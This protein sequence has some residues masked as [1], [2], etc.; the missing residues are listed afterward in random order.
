VSCRPKEQLSDDEDDVVY[1]ADGELGEAPAN[2]G[3]YEGGYGKPKTSTA[4]PTKWCLRECERCAFAGVNLPA[5]QYVPLKDFS[6]RRY[7]Q[8]WKHQKSTN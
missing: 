1:L 5:D 2:P 4:F 8:P 7:N 3:T 6:V